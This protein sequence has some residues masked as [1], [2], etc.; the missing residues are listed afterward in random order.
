MSSLPARSKPRSSRH[1]PRITSGGIVGSQPNATTA[2]SPTSSDGWATTTSCSRP[3]TRTR[4][5]SIRRP[6]STSSPWI[7]SSYPRRASARSCGTTPSTCTGSPPTTS[8]R[9]ERRAMIRRPYAAVDHE[10][11]IRAYPPP[12]EY[13][14]A[15]WFAPPDEIEAVQLTG[16]RRGAEVPAGVP[17]FERRWA[18]AGFD[19]RSIRIRAALWRAPAY[20]VEDIRKS[21][22]LPPP[23]GDY[24]GVTPADAVRE[25]MRVYMSG[26]TTGKSRPTF[27]TQWDREV[28]AVLTARA[29]YLQGIRPGDVVL[30]SGAY[31]P[32]NGAFAFDEALHRWLNWV[33]LT[34]GTGNVTSSERQVELAIEYGATAILTTG[35]YLLRLAVVAREM[36]YDPST[37][38]K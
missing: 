12:P 27:Y 16:H 36:G 9:H 8:R 13:F 1:Q 26:G 30:N 31:G 25:P 4:T 7:R 32:H 20:T 11:L 18:A 15:A 35:D 29:L 10:A 37:D 21:I 28:G 22:A 17:F 33:V 19:P 5:P 38:F 3:I 34:T 23:W 24:Q 6:P 14:E 2:S